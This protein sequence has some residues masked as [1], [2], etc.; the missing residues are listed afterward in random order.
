[1]YPLVRFSLFIFESQKIK[2]I[3]RKGNIIDT[4][5]NECVLLIFELLFEKQLLH[6]RENFACIV[7]YNTTVE[8][9]VTIFMYELV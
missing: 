1:M 5:Q 9:I 6:R 3:I 2:Y 4:H 7:F 8:F